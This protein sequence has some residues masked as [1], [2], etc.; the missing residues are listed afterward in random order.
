M[1]VNKLND[2]IFCLKNSIFRRRAVTLYNDALR[3]Q[4]LSEKEFYSECWEHRLKIVKYA[5][6][7]IPFYKKYYDS[8]GFK[9]SCLLSEKDWNNIPV[10]EKH[11]IREC[12]D[13]FINPN[14]PK[15]SLS[16][17]TTGGSTGYPLRVGRD[18]R[19]KLEVVAWRFLE[20]WGV[21]Y[22]DNT[23]ITHRR[24]PHN[25][26]QVLKNRFIW[27]PTKRVYLSATSMTDDQ[28]KTFVENLEKKKIVWLT[29]YVGALERIA[30]YMETHGVKLTKLK[31]VWSTSAPLT[32]LSRRKMESVFGCKV[33]DQYGC[34]EV[35]QIA[36]QCPSSEHLHVNCDFVHVDVVNQENRSVIDEEG[37]ILVTDLYNY[38]FPI[39]RYRLGDRGCML[40][41]RCSCGKP[42]P[43]MK[44]VKGRISDAVYTP[45]GIYVDGSFLTTI[46][47]EYSEYI[48]QFQIHQYKDYHVI[49]SVKVKEAAPTN[50]NS[51]L[52]TVLLQM[53]QSVNNEIPMEIIK[54]DRITHD[55]GKVRYV[56]SDI[57]LPN[58]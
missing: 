13:M 3:R 41:E 31:L 47:D 45:S 58:R 57:T 54:V 51:I 38:A 44:S 30:E 2:F 49:I 22:A 15:S 18:R 53:K 37:D 25:M 52:E 21:S 11:H 12:S 6:E 19:F 27:W 39:I 17:T 20:W 29:G 42:F 33:M 26:L 55:R 7:H 23:A 36:N 48:D 32:E 56:I 14:A 40:S 34:C 16:Y 9:P 28:I 10:V 5:Y 4:N 35:S 50:I 46:F 8:V 43:L 1:P 24:I